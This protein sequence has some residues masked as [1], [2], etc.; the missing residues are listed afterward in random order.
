MT[1]PWR[2]FC[3]DA[4]LAVECVR[5][6]APLSLRLAP[7][8]ADDAIE[9]ACAAVA[10]GSRVATALARPP[11]LAALTE[12]AGRSRSEEAAV[13]VAV[14]APPEGRDRA[15][16]VA[17][18]LG[19]VAVPE[20]RPLLSA[21][22]LL[23]VP[24]PQPWLASARGLTAL[25]RVRLG[26]HTLAAGRGG[27]RLVRVDDGRLG[28]TGRTSELFVLGEPGDV[29]EA[30]RA[31]RARTEAS[32]PARAVIE[33][34]DRASVL[35]VIFGPPRALS[36]PASK[37]ALEPYGIPLPMEELCTSPSRAASEAARIGFPVRI[38]LAS[39]D[40]RIWDHPD[41]AVDGVDNAAR[42]RDVYRQIIAMAS[43]RQPEARLLGVV[44]TATTS[45]QALLRVTAEP[46]PEG[47]VLAE[48]GFADAHGRAALDRTYTVLPASHEAV[49]R[50]LTR[51]AGSELLVGG[52]P[53]QRRACVGAIADVLLRVAA[54]VDEHRGEVDRVELNPV[55]LLFSGAVEMREACITVGDA[56]LRSLDAPRAANEPT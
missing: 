54:F 53:A 17:R 48:I 46:L 27:G 15:L 21:M 39:P 10:R 42:V 43:E 6:A 37:A 45:A 9:R 26:E 4:E 7:E 56:F 11:N 44:V 41:L 16:L 47:S 25:D 33:G 23:D 18:D 35:Q 1:E 50:V 13:P 31:L 29:G 20:V 34:V 40:L 8:I 3:D 5:A 14:I 38:S 36:D 49:D 30:L 12:L 32:P 55:A 28:W 22:A 19:L 52:G 2:I 51:L 24:T